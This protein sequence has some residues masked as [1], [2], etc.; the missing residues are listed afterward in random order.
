MFSKRVLVTLVVSQFAL[1][2][3]VLAQ[4][5]PRPTD[6]WRANPNTGSYLDDLNLPITI[7]N[8]LPELAEDGIKSG[9]AQLRVSEDGLN[10]IVDQDTARL[11]AY[12]GSYNIGERN[13]VTYQQPNSEAVALN[14]I[15]QQSPSQILGSLNCNGACWLINPNG[16][17]FGENAQ[18]DTHGLIAAAM[19]FN[20]APMDGELSEQQ[21]ARFE[22][23]PLFN[24]INRG[25][26][27]L[28]NGKDLAEG[29]EDLP[30]IIVQQGA[31]IR[32]DQAPILLAG[33]EV[34]NEGSIDSDGGQ[35]V[36]A[37]SRK[38][39][40]LALTNPLD[41]DYRGYLIEVDSGDREDGARGAVVNAGA[42]TANLGNVTLVASEIVQAGQIKSSTAVDVNG[43]IRILARDRAEL[44]ITSQFREDP[45]ERQALYFDVNTEVPVTERIAVGR[46]AGD[47]SLREGSS[48]EIA[49]DQSAATA[50]D[51]LDQPK[52]QVNIEG[53]YVVMEEGASIVAPSGEVTVRARENTIG[54]LNAAE[55]TD[56]LFAMGAGSVIDVSGTEDT[57][58]S[59]DRNTIDFFITSNELRDAPEQ[60]GGVLLRSTLSVDIRRGTPL[61]DWTEGLENIEKTASERSAGGGSVDILAKGSVTID[62]AAVIDVSGGIVSYEAGVVETTRLLGGNGL[63]D[64][65]EANPLDP[66]A[67]VSGSE[68]Q[69]LMDP[70]WGEINSFRPTPTVSR[71]YREAYFEGFGAGAIT[72]NAPHQHIAGDAQFLA[73]TR[74]GRFQREGANLPVGGSIDLVFAG[75]N[76]NHDVFI[77]DQA[78]AVAEQIVGEELQLSR[79]LIE[80]SGAAQ[81]TIENGLGL[82]VQERDSSLRLRQGTSLGLAGRGVYVFGDIRTSGGDVALRQVGEAPQDPNGLEGTLRV[83]GTIDTRGAWV[84]DNPELSAGLQERLL[85]D[86]GDISLQASA[87][88]ELG[89]TAALVADAGARA[90]TTGALAIGKAGDITLSARQD[91]GGAELAIE[92]PLNVSALD[93]DKGGRLTIEATDVTIGDFGDSQFAADLRIDNTFFDSTQVGS[94][95]FVAVDGNATLRSDADIDL[96]HASL[97]ANADFF[98]TASAAD[99][100]SVLRAARLP[101]YL[102]SSGELIVDALRASEENDA[103]GIL[104]VEAGS[105]IL[106]PA[107]SS[108]DLLANNRLLLDGEIKIAGGSVNATL[109]QVRLEES[110]LSNYMLVGDNADIDLSATAIDIPTNTLVTEKKLV[111]AGSL[112]LNA[113]FG[114]AL[115]AEQARIDLSGT[116]VETTRRIVS[117]DNSNGALVDIRTPLA[118]G[119]FTVAAEEGFD[120]AA[121]ID[122]GDAGEGYGGG[123][124]GYLLTNDIT[125]TRLG[126]TISTETD[127]NRDYPSLQLILGD[128]AVASATDGLAFG[129]AIDVEFTGLGHIATGNLNRSHTASMILDVD[130]SIA[131][132]LAANNRIT[133]SGDTLI[134]ATTELVLD[135][136]NLFLQAADLELLAPYVQLGQSADATQNLQVVIPPEQGTGSLLVDA[137]LVD[138]FGNLSVS[139]ADELAILASSGVR[140]RSALNRSTDTTPG[141]SGLTTAADILLAAPL[142]W[143]ETLSDYSFDLVGA[144][145]VFEFAGTGSNS[146]PI[147]S[148]GAD[149]EINAGTI[150]IDSTID[151]PFGA[152][153]LNAADTVRLGQRA[154]LSV[155]GTR[156]VPLGRIEADGVSWVYELSSSGAP[157]RFD[158]L[159]EK[160]VAVNAPAIEA[161]EGSEIDLS[162]GGR[163]Y[164]REFVAGL[165]GSSDIL[166]NRPYTESFVILPEHQSGYAPFDRVEFEGSGI[167]WGTSFEVSGSDQLADGSYTVLPANY[168]LLPGALLITPESNSGG[169]GEGFNSRNRFGAEVV[170]G[171]FSSAG[172]VGAANWS[173][174]RVEPGS[175]VNE[176]AEYRITDADAF[177]AFDQPGTRPEENGRLVV[178]ADQSLQFGG[179]ILSS[180]TSPVGVSFDLA[181][182]GDIVIGESPVDGA[183]LVDPNLF[184]SIDADSVLIGGERSWQGDAWGVAPL[185]RSVTFDGA[186]IATQELL[187]TADEEVAL[188]NNSRID[189]T[190]A[191]SFSG[192]TWRPGNRGVTA[193]FS[194]TAGSSLD[195]SQVSD[196]DGAFVLQQGS[197]VT[198]GGAIGIAYDGVDSLAQLSL[199]G[200]QAETR[201]QVAA[202]TIVVGDTAAG[203]AIDGELLQSAQLSELKA[204]STIAFN[205]SLTA[206]LTELVLRSR[207]IDID[208]A[209][210]IS[211][212]ASQSITLI[213]DSPVDIAADTPAAASSLALQAA[214]ITIQSGRADDESEASFLF[215]DAAVTS[216]T[217]T[218]SLHTSG[219]VG[220]SASGDMNIA[221]NIIGARGFS[222]F[223]A[224]ARGSLALTQYSAAPPLDD[225]GRIFSPGAIFHFDGDQ[226]VS[227]DTRIIARSG[228][229]DIASKHGDAVLGENASLDV[230]A[231]RVAFPDQVR[232]APAGTIAVRAAG[233]LSVADPTAFIFGSA[234]QS[235]TEGQLALL[236]G[237]QLSLAGGGYDGSIGQWSAGGVDLTLQAGSIAAGMDNVA[238]LNGNGFDGDI[239]ILLTGAGEDLLLGSG[240]S[241][242]GANIRL[243]TLSGELTIA[244]DLE[245]TGATEK[246]VLYGG[247]GV[248]VADS[249]AVRVAAS[250][251]ALSV[252]SIPSILSIQSP[253]ADVQVAAGAG[254]TL[255]GGLEI[256][257]SAADTLTRVVVDMADT[258]GGTI[259]LLLSDSVARAAID[260][261]DLDALAGDLINLADATDASIFISAGQPLA[262]RPLLDIYATDSLSVSALDLTGLRTAAGEAGVLQLRAAGDI[263]INGGIN[264][265]TD[266][267]V[268][269]VSTQIL[270]QDDSWGIKLIAGSD[271]ASAYAYSDFRAGSGSITLGGNAFVQTGTGDIQVFAAGD[272]TLLGDSYIAALGKT[273]YLEDDFF[274]PGRLLPAWGD[275]IYSD[276]YPVLPDFSGFS[277]ESGDI[278]MDIGG[279]MRGEGSSQTPATFIQRLSV[280]DFVVNNV[281]YSGIRT[282]TLAVDQIKG[283]IHAVGGGSIE[284]A[285][286]GDIDNVGFST[287]GLGL[288]Y[289]ADRQFELLSGG[290]LTVNSRANIY[291]SSFANDGAAINVR[292]FG[293]IGANDSLAGSSLLLGSDTEMTLLAGAD[294]DVDAIVNTFSLPASRSQ[295]A[296]V[297]LP[298]GFESQASTFVYG[299]DTTAVR[300]TSV[301]GAVTLKPGREGVQSFLPANEFRTVYQDTRDLRFSLL[302]SVVEISALSGDIV[303]DENNLYL[304]PSAQ[305]NF[306][307]AAGADIL[308]GRDNV[309][310]RMPDLTADV[311]P[312]ITDVF[313]PEGAIRVRDSLGRPTDTSNPLTRLDNP[314]VEGAHSESLIDRSGSGRVGIFAL[315]GDIGD[316]LDLEFEIPKQV[317]VFAG[318]D[319]INTTFDIQHGAS[320]DISQ[321]VATGDILFPVSIRDNGQGLEPTGAKGIKLAGPGDLIVSAGGDIDLGTTGGIESIGNL[322]NPALPSAGASV[323]VYA[324]F[325]RRGDYKALVGDGVDGNQSIASLADFNLDSDSLEQLSAVDWFAQM[326][327]VTGAESDAYGIMIDSVSRA[328]G[329]SYDNLQQALADWSAFDAT[330]QLRVSVSA[331]KDVALA[332]PGFFVDNGDILFATPALGEAGF[333][334][335]QE[336]R[337]AFEDYWNGI[338]SLIA[339]EYLLTPDREADLVAQLPAGQS[340]EAFSAQPLSTQLNTAV[341]TFDATD[342]TRQLLI[343]ERITVEHTKQGGREGLNAGNSLV[344]FER[345]YTAQRMFFGADFDAAIAGM[346][347]KTQAIVSGEI[348]SPGEVTFGSRDGRELDSIEEVFAAWQAGTGEDFSTD[349]Q[350]QPGG[351]ISLVFS[352]IRSRSGGDVNVMAPAG[353]VDVGLAAAQLQALEIDKAPDEQGVLA[354]GLGDVNGIVAD[355]YNVNESRSFSLAGGDMNL[356]SSFGDIDAGRGA[357]T[358]FVTPPAEF[359]ISVET[360]AITVVRPPAVSGSGIRTSGSRSS[361]GEELS[362][363]QRF[364]SLAEGPGA[365]FLSTA[366]GIVDAGEAGI[367]SAGDLFIAAAEVRGADNI[368][369]G[370]VSVGVT[371]DTTVSAA[372]AGVGDAA[373]AATESAQNAV[374]AAAS[375]A[376]ADGGTAFITIELI[377]TGT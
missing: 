225:P 56:A 25:E 252:P 270:L 193:L 320:G 303:L 96:S 216:L 276:L 344:N 373:N 182:S 116:V 196:P 4:D 181:A 141:S 322:E 79:D 65:S 157:V 143:G 319:I 165:G 302:P 153:T 136:P 179:A 311:V 119:S 155:A 161:A 28:V 93:G 309:T 295:R 112:A 150:V 361:T 86:A 134:R 130:N 156:D 199:G 158:S 290:S 321:V 121:T 376:D 278:R 283:G 73:G 275:R 135:T 323:H 350:A 76:D 35:V 24:A 227:V 192:N 58:V 124:Q 347:D 109:Q 377:D 230:G 357:K 261:Q 51:G 70:K 207:R 120:I 82:V 285:A 83:S 30:R 206:A 138:F 95:R 200:G 353:S 26:A 190:A 10:L 80:N 105:R 188:Q 215:A 223:S 42:L 177:F 314:V 264:A 48:M 351:D 247:A 128:D 72:I 327:A 214:Q 185:A 67:G 371:T 166:V 1:P 253:E 337:Q 258:V 55:D 74:V 236:S 298:G 101:D 375:G 231:Y 131:G 159:P 97:V 336:R 213:G 364:Y 31:Q 115:V 71:Y 81:F 246:V 85:I 195:L 145:S 180:L 197:S 92:G 251:A 300:L 40:Y 255:A 297:G 331:M 39:V 249:A 232:S 318:G 354:L 343:A 27:F 324:G 99:A 288:G 187:V 90:T 144:D 84:N 5:L 126:E 218:E 122:F 341:A 274:F 125:T 355:A 52:S 167:P 267:L 254:L 292:A 184:A 358:A 41:G 208:E 23:E 110:Q 250:E 340:L 284:V 7:E 62:E 372:V 8:M 114:Y 29:S 50:A 235:G 256:V 265:A 238:L 205:Q 106:G 312:T 286:R 277:R 234:E 237:G 294:L 334:S 91:A 368:N 14:I 317:D 316:G 129:D 272:F 49:I 332:D 210:D 118:A 305:S 34:I 281:D 168:A 194:T 201:L 224:G 174:F 102:A 228:Y 133:V 154:R 259:S 198:A 11:L 163:I 262:V 104:T 140:L 240:D 301:A 47:V 176:R 169:V 335:E 63:V 9:E 366:L 149:L 349:P 266:T 191:P 248:N 19:E 44:F 222:E 306:T 38:D 273:D 170:S 263:S 78:I 127:A 77:V 362:S 142:M 339:L 6:R 100:G 13:A 348:S 202:D 3:T 360:G 151:N 296:I 328:S 282:W 45:L 75:A 315:A 269:P 88:L 221:A 356:W 345:G 291:H 244:G 64:I 139:G 226:A 173:G 326:G 22:N 98:N 148:V 61:F 369:V 113:L 325:N 68:G 307:L 346:V 243:A 359:Q 333:A 287:P 370:G 268:G 178:T 20:G 117:G 94:Y 172:Q 66:Y 18:I 17:I 43:S 147:L 59:A 367:E 15:Q 171:R 32:S 229:I 21:L 108:V 37:G 204:G 36:L 310:F 241:L 16:I 299:F 54:D 329:R 132:G 186:D 107:A 2:V 304:Y 189:S 160:V 342:S 60:K 352:V 245:A 69:L 152:I 257:K 12:W 374:A 212:S 46:E 239:D 233:D 271:P 87:R 365:T 280:D 146:S 330:L 289:T 242:S 164:G 220:L 175:V 363:A 137:E 89:R 293:A 162:G 209:V 103:A 313:R 53:R 338:G 279:S 211:L 217:A 219:T 57:V 260:Q 308:A 203:A 183:L 123:R 33:P 111:D